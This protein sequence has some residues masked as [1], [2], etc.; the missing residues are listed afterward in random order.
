MDTL[1]FSD[2]RRIQK[3]ERNSNELTDLH[4]DF[5]VQA[6]E[7]LERKRE[8]ADN[9]EFNSSKRVYNK[10]VA[11]REQK[12]VKNARMALRSNIKASE[13]NLLPR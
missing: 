13:L 8:N 6:N 11:L 1:T 3:D 7:Y 9:R 5:I 4:E 12:V 2:L 10:I